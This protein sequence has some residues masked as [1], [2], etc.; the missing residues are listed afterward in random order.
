MTI[1]CNKTRLRIC[2]APY[3]HSFSSIVEL[4]IFSRSEKQIV[5]KEQLDTVITLV[6]KFICKT[7]YHSVMHHYHDS[8]AGLFN[9]VN[10]VLVVRQTTTFIARYTY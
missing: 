4:A 9:D 5:G 1:S 3:L 6:C 10:R 8:E 7:V 2:L